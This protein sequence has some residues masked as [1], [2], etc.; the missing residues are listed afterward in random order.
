[1]L[2]LLCLGSSNWITKPGWQHIWL[3][4]GLL[5]FLSLLLR[6]EVKCWLLGRVKFFV[7]SWNIARQ[8]PQ[9]MKFSRQEYW[10]GLPFLSPGDLPDPGIKPGSPALLVDTL[11]S[12]PPGKH[13]WDLLPQKISFKVVLLIDNVLGHPRVLMQMISS[14]QFS[15]L[16]VSDALRP[17]WL[18]YTKL[19]YPSPTPGA[20]SNSCSLRWWCCPTI[21]P[22][23]ILLSSCLQSFPTSGSFQMSQ[24]FTSGSQSIGVSVSASVL[25]MNIQDQFPLGWTGWISLQSM[26]FSRVFSNTT[27]Q[28]HQ[29]FG[30]Q[31]SL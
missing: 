21:L 11:P 20:Y 3:Q 5:R 22:S 29:F 1:M 4:Q 7:T 16:V 18:Q 24:L 9:S 2:N 13:C 14:V 25:P 30:A 15:H 28:K 31:L 10:S 23:V 26:G 27:V 12:Q 19:P 6:L 17:H 8:A